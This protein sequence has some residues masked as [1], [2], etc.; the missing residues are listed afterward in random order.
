M[1]LLRMQPEGSRLVTPDLASGT[2]TS[3]PER[4][5]KPVVS[6]AESDIHLER[7]DEVLDE[8]IGRFPK[9]DTAIDPWLAPRVHRALP[10]T[11]RQAADAGVW[12]YLA[13]VHR[14][15]VVRHRWENLS[16]ATMR[17]RFW[18]M[19]TRPTSTMFGRLW[20]IAELTRDRDSYELTERVFGRQ[21]LATQIFVRSWSQYRSAVDAF[22]DV[23]QD[24]A[25]DEVE[26]GARTLTRRLATVPLEGLSRTELVE[27]LRKVRSR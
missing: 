26:H 7:L 12:R 27:F 19:G 13:V 25:G 6:D 4:E 14:P 15:D 24:A 17:S 21:A 22:A 20:W 23:F 11:R 3:W 2:R 16:W 8:L 1:K 9:F 10:L 5:W 18:S